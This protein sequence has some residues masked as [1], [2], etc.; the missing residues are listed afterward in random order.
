[1]A[2]AS[3]REKTLGSNIEKMKGLK[4]TDLLVPGLF[5]LIVLLLTFFVFIPSLEDTRK[6]RSQL[7]DVNKNQAI[8]EKNLEKNPV[9]F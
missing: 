8:L 6:M 9:R 7:D 5:I 4:L 2:I 3:I 1:M